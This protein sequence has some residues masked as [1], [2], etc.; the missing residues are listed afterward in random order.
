[1]L[2]PT[3]TPTLARWFVDIFDLR[4][5]PH[6]APRRAK[7]RRRIKRHERRQNARHIAAE[8]REMQSTREEREHTMFPAAIEVCANP[9]ADLAS[10]ED[11]TRYRRAVA[12]P[13]QPVQSLSTIAVTTDTPT[14]EPI[15]TTNTLLPELGM[16]YETSPQ[17][18]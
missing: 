9:C 17:A 8:L 12:R 1:M 14:E 5:R 10:D 15:E 2:T 18:R 16:R 3:Y 4:P 6:S 11:V 7:I 13:V